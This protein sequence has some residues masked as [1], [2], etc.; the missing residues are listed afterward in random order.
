MLQAL[1]ERKAN[2]ALPKQASGQLNSHLS[3]DLADA[4]GPSELPSRDTS[5]S[6]SDRAGQNGARAGP[7]APQG[8]SVQ[9]SR[10][11]GPGSIAAAK[12]AGAAE[13][14]RVRVRPDRHEELRKRLDRDSSRSGDSSGPGPVP[15]GNSQ[16]AAGPSRLGPARDNNRAEAVSVRDPVKN[17]R[18]RQLQVRHLSALSSLSSI[19][20]CLSCTTPSC[21]VL[22]T[23][24]LK[25]PA[26]ATIHCIS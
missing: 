16:R 20:A 12:A 21:K 4:A 15:K 11:G 17:G 10:Q 22:L 14:V 6:D 8:R 9:P 25:L 18:K 13:Q 2:K 24:D 5:S 19:L 7:N 26:A 1:N 3:R 23:T